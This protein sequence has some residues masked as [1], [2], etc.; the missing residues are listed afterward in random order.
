M[1]KVHFEGKNVSR[2]FGVSA[3][4]KRIIWTRTEDLST[5]YS[6]SC[7]VGLDEEHSLIAARS[8]SNSQED[9]YDFV[10]E[11]ITE[12]YLKPG[13]LLVCDN[14]AVYGG[15]EYLEH[16]QELVSIH[17]IDIRF[18]PTYSPE[19]NSCEL[20]FSFVKSWLRYYRCIY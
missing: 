5:R 16:L 10:E 1:D 4:G 19:F 11:S 2:R 8:N 9:F 17:N 20:V 3:I 18:L 7:I 6:V 15:A 12:G 14:A 13:Q